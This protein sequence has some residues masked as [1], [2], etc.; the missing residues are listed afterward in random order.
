MTDNHRIGGNQLKYSPGEHALRVLHCVRV[1][2]ELVTLIGP[3][4]FRERQ[5]AQDHV[6]V[7]LW[8]FKIWPTFSEISVE[9]LYRKKR[10][11]DLDERGE[12]QLTMGIAMIVRPGEIERAFSIK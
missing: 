9:N 1:N 3:V 8:E 7:S 11:G 6:L 12:L 10:F 4:N 5:P 2:A